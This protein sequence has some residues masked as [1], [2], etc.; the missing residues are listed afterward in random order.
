MEH[1]VPAW[2]LDIDVTT[3]YRIFHIAILKSHWQNLGIPG[4]RNSHCFLFFSQRV[5]YKRRQYSFYPAA[6]I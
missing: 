6:K 3:T 2:I 4:I 1:I 5:E